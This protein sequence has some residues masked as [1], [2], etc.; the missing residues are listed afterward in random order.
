MKEKSELERMGFRQFLDFILEDS[1]N[2]DTA[3]YY[4]LTKQMYIPLSHIYRDSGRVIL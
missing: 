4:L 2:S 3:M 1:T